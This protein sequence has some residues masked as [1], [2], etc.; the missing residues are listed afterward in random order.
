MAC[1]TER[2]APKNTTAILTKLR[3][4]MKNKAY[5]TEPLHAYIV[6]SG[7]AHQVNI[8]IFIETQVYLAV[9]IH[10]SRPVFVL[11]AFLSTL[12]YLCS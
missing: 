11:L 1:I 12:F 9:Q 4:L 7:D 3:G 6:P 5:V 10:K 2:M 8:Y